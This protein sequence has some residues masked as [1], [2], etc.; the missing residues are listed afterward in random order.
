[1]S[2]KYSSEFKAKVAL[3]AVSQGRTVIEKIAEKYDLSEDQVIAWT[4]QLHEDAARIFAAQSA[5]EEESDAEDVE[6][7]TED[8]E[9]AVA[10]S[11]GVMS[12]EL[13]YKK[14]IFWSS[15]GTALVIIFVIGLVFFSQYSLFEAQRE[16][17]N[18]TVF[19]DV[20]DLYERQEEEL[21]SF[22][23]VDIEEGIYRIPIDSAISKIAVD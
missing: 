3:E 22:G 18:Q 9:F 15:F 1:M 11:Q 21:N 20:N 5:H 2:E 14:L 16:V 23:V 12:D 8:D 6:I 17:S 19:S 10:V 4:A 13:N 7:A